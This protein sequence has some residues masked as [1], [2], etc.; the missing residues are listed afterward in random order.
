MSGAAAALTLHKKHP[1]PIGN[2]AHVPAKP[3]LLNCL[4]L[5]FRRFSPALATPEA[6]CLRES[7]QNSAALS[8]KDVRLRVARELLGLIY[9]QI[10]VH[11][12][13]SRRNRRNQFIIGIRGTVYQSFRTSEVSCETLIMYVAPPVLLWIW[14]KQPPL[15]GLICVIPSFRHWI[16]KRMVVQFEK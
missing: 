14:L 2:Y 9:S 16:I 15:I 4:H 6:A 1:L 8:A 12:C 13:I 10:S 5:Q 7:C 3:S 11:E